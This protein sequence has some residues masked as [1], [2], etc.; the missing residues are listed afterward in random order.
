MR[1]APAA[2]TWQR[3]RRLVQGR[4][5]PVVIVDLD[6]VDANIASLLEPVRRHGKTLRVATKSIRCPALLRHVLAQGGEAMRGL[7]TYTATETAFLADQGFDD[8]ILAYPTVQPSDLGIVASLN[9]RGVRAAIV[10]DA[11]EHVACIDLAARELGC[12]IPVVVELDTS[13]RPARLSRAHIGA[14][15]S[16]LRTP[17]DVLALVQ[18]IAAAT[19]LTFHGLMAYESHIAGVTDASPFDSWMNAP[20]RLMKR[21]ARGPLERAR[22]EVAAHLREHGVSL[23]VFNGGGTGSLTWCA[24]ESALT[25]VSAGS[26]FLGS[27]LFDYYADFAVEPAI[28]FALQVVRRP[29]DGIVTCHGGGYIASGETG[30]DRQP[31]PALPAGLTLLPREGAGE[32][33]TPVHVPPG[34]E[35]RIGDP[36][37]FRHAK[38]G[39]LAEHAN[40][41]LLVRGDRVVETAL[42]Y[43]GFGHC[44][45]G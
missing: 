1:G 43:R 40:E 5:L 2:E 33:Q 17:S 42:T 31:V 12:K 6:A 32:V 34:A 21:L 44:F 22:E 4:S 10:V 26:G 19:S 36:I 38:A 28:H 29:A 27:H 3:Y 14:R 20:K 11:A 18:T 37:F 13:Y 23:T 30:R 35:L 24:T 16:P 8:F 45:L 7:L 9:A 25:E 39:E 41:Y 15:R